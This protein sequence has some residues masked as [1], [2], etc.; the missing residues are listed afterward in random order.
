[1]LPKDE[2]CPDAWLAP[3]QKPDR[4]Q[5]RGA[6][7]SVLSLNDSVLSLD[8]AESVLSRGTT[9]KTSTKKTVLSL[10][11]KQQSVRE[12]RSSKRCRVGRNNPD[13][14][15]GPN[16]VL[17]LLSN[18]GGSKTTQGKKSRHGKPTEATDRDLLSSLGEPDFP[19]NQGRKRLY[20][21]QKVYE[22]HQPPDAAAVTWQCPLCDFSLQGQAK[23]VGWGK[24]R[25]VKPDTPRPITKSSFPNQRL[26]KSLLQPLSLRNSA[27]GNALFV[28]LDFR[29]F[30][31]VTHTLLFNTTVRLF[32]LRLMLKLGK[33][34]M[35]QSGPNV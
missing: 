30:P 9:T 15:S 12:S 24:R 19:K 6:G 26:P 27:V 35:S 17:D 8:T 28:R 16:S 21:K 2:P 34:I 11:R 5:L 3:T 13:A 25:H 20:G 33:A 32:T 1:M 22:W 29:A 10:P 7:K 31:N 14:K 23:Q 18:S 4:V